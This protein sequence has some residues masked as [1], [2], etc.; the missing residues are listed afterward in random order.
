MIGTTFVDPSES[1]PT[2]GRLLVIG[3]DDSN[4]SWTQLSSIQ[5][6][7]C[8]YALA[9]VGANTHV[10]AAINSQVGLATGRNHRS[11]LTSYLQVT[12]YTVDAFSQ[13][14]TAV[15]SWGGAFI[16]FNLAATGPNKTDLLVG[17]ALR[18][19]TV[20]AFSSDPVTSLKEIS[21]DYDAH[22]TSAVQQ[23][24]EDEYIGAE[25]DLNLFTVL[26]EKS[27]TTRSALHDDAALSPRA[28]FH[29]GE[30]VTKFLPGE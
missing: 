3:E 9:A 17:D 4:R 27:S 12:V 29:L 8:P 19:V 28:A 22:Y 24:D 13:T 5:I 21:S 11:A 18:S 16:A 15:S 30:L 23:I 2:K 1:E 20:L 25:T 14:L 26:K 10:A 7:G 6:G